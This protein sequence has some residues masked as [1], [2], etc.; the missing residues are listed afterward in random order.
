MNEVV[1]MRV[2]FFAIVYR[3]KKKREVKNKMRKILSENTF[4]SFERGRR[5]FCEN[6]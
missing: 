5:A 6:E 1:F 2:T 3:E 4:A